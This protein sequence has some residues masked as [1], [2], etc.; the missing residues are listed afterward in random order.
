MAIRDWTARQLARTAGFALR[1][2]SALQRREYEGSDFDQMTASV[3][4]GPRWLLT[5]RSE[6]SLR[7]IFGV[8]S[9]DPL[10]AI[11][12]RHSY[13]L[14]FSRMNADS[15]C[16]VFSSPASSFSPGST[17]SRL[18]IVSDSPIML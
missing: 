8:V 9:V 4:A 15:V 12:I 2:A 5:P 6:A 3:H 13:S 1:G 17:T 16:T 7:P 14:I 11:T 10:S 18:V